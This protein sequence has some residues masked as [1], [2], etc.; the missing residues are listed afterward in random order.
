MRLMA[1][2]AHPDDA[3]IWCG[4]T[5]I[6]HAAKGDEVGICILSYS[7]D[8]E[9]GQEAKNSAAQMGCRLDLLG[10]ED[11]G[12]KDTVEEASRLWQCIE[13]FIPDTIITHWFD[14]M[15]PDHV[16][17][18][19]LLRR[20]LLLG[21]LNHYKDDPQII[22]RLFCCD[23]IGSMGL[24]GPFNPDRYVDVTAA[25]EKKIAAINAH[26]SQILDYYLSMIEK[27][28]IAHGQAS[29]KQRAEAF[30]Y[31]PF[32]GAVDNGSPLGG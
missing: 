12:I 14:D 31:L 6:L 30:L 13:S 22:P 8:S 20:A 32:F 24:H 29:G 9:R 3:E 11:A 16:A 17:T 4:G 21:Y 25:W 19:N 15:H 26:Q 7:E 18:F 2:M 1:V 23:N 10:M 27:Q 28:C 5:L